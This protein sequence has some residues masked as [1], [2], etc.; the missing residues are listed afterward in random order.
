[1]NERIYWLDTLRAIGIFF[2]VLLHTGRV[3]ESHIIAHI[4]SCDV[5]LFF[6]ISGLLATEK[7]YRKSLSS[8][9][10]KLVRRSLVPYICFAAISYCFWLFVLQHFKSN[11][12]DPWHSLLGIFYSSGSGGWLS[13]N[14][15]LWYFTC[16]FVVQAIF[17]VLMRW[18]DR[19]SPIF[20]LPCYLL[21]LS[22]AGYIVTTYVTSVD[23]RLPWS[24]DIALTATVF[25]GVGYLLQPYILTD[26]FMRWQWLG[27][28]ISALVSIVCSSI[29]NDVEFYVGVYGNYFYFYLSAFSGI[30]FWIYIARWL[31]PDRLV[32]AIGQNTLVIFST[33]LLVIPCLTG[34]FTYVL[35]IPEQ[36]LNDSIFSSIG[37]AVICILTI[38]PIALL[39]NSHLPILVGKPTSKTI[40]SAS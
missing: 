6:F 20:L 21:L 9:L 22:I 3:H 40:G 30:M 35:K 27:L 28:S 23:S 2:I 14:I 34:F 7:S 11:P 5:P 24:I 8:Y 31:K 12:F 15:A 13:F 36:I 1:M 39:I 32:T 19:T 29:E 17:Y 4:K 16:L 18:V 38:L 37:Y 26:R 25:Y 10:K 33:H